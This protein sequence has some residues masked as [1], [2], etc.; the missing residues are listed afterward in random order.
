MADAVNRNV[1]KWFQTL[2]DF[3]S[4]GSLIT[5]HDFF[6]STD[7]VYVGIQRS[8]KIA[9]ENAAKT[10]RQ[11]N[12]VAYLAINAQAKTDSTGMTLRRL[13]VN[14]FNTDEFSHKVVLYNTD[15]DIDASNPLMTIDPIVEFEGFFVTDIM[16]P[17]PSSEELGYQPKCVFDFWVRIEEKDTNNPVTGARCLKMQPSWM[18]DNAEQLGDA[19]FSDLMMVKT[20]D[21]AAYK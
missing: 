16:L 13:E 4:I 2:P 14:W 15:P 11:A 21:S 9:A 10:M 6:L 7:M 12:P 18:T 5:G 8:L 20:H 17:Q 1:T 3:T 19:K